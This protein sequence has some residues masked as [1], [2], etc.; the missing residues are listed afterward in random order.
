MQ[1][2]TLFTRVLV[3]CSL[4]TQA[5][6]E[7]PLLDRWLNHQADITTWQAD[8]SQTRTIKNLT[9]PLTQ[10][11][12]LWFTKPSQFRWQLG[13]PARTLAV[14][15]DKRLVVAYPRL[16]QA[17]IYAFDSIQDPAM[18]QVL[19][20]LELGFPSEPAAFFAQYTLLDSQANADQTQLF[21]LQPNSAI[22]RK[23]LE[24]VA[25]EVDSSNLN[26]LATTLFF[27]DGSRLNNVFEH[28]QYNIPIE[29]SL[30]QLDLTG[31]DISQPLSQ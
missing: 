13:E 16:K 11:G 17:E 21:T 29:A 31:F 2:L 23:L 26:L 10:K 3:L 12:K 7:S 1:V 20:L 14:R 6:A 8:V 25:L 15:D 27:T 9:Q 24:K 30:L 18:K 4:S 28:Q 22:A 19:L 5:L